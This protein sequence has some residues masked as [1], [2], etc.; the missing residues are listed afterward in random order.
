MTRELRLITHELVYS[1]FGITNWPILFTFCRP[2]PGRGAPK[3]IFGVAPRL[4]CGLERWPVG[5]LL[6][7]LAPSVRGLCGVHDDL[8]SGGRSTAAFAGIAGCI[9]T[10]TSSMPVHR[11]TCGDCAGIYD[12]DVGL[13]GA[14]PH[15][16]GSPSTCT[17]VWEPLGCTAAPAG[18]A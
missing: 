3:L 13:G 15:L 12:G 18:I 1:N 14:P 5:W 4:F 8:V 10:R 9:S 6:P 2:A 7:R 16:R 11:R 17:T